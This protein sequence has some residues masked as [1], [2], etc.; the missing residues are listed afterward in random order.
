MSELSKKIDKNY[1]KLSQNMLKLLD[2]Q[3]SYKI[4]KDPENK[5]IIILEN[6]NNEMLLSAKFNYIGIYNRKNNIWYWGWSLVKDKSLTKKSLLVKENLKD[7]DFK[8]LVESNNFTVKEEDLDNIIK[9]ALYYMEDIWY[10]VIRLDDD[11][12]QFISIEEILENYI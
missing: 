4:R 9:I 1:D 12:I 8:I 11:I 7:P 5:D 2:P 10:F 6:D 3:V